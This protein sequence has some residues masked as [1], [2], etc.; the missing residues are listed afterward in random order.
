LFLQSAISRVTALQVDASGE[1]QYDAVLRQGMDKSVV[2]YS[3]FTDLVEKNVEASAL[4]RPDEDEQKR[5]TDRTRAALEKKM[6]GSCLDF[7]FLSPPCVWIDEEQLIVVYQT[8]RSNQG[9]ATQDR[10]GSELWRNLH[11]IHPGSSSARRFS[12][13]WCQ[14]AHCAITGNAERPS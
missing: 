11:S 7:F 14:A 1:V 8:N 3:K 5:I 10:D 9:C 12:Q 6:E 4:Q 2:M 13:F